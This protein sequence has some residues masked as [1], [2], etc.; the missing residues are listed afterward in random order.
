[1]P[2]WELNQ[3]PLFKPDAVATRTGWMDPV[4]GE[5]LVAIGS[6]PTKRRNLIDD[7][8]DNLTLGDGFDL[9]LNTVSDETIAPEFLSL[10]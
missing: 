4:T 9:L 6:L 10:E 3:P 7:G 8:I 2:L 1:M 5:I